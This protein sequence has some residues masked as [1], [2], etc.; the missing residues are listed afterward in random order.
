MEKRTQTTLAA[1]CGIT[2]AHLSSVE[3][4]LRNCSYPIA[5]LLGDITGSDPVIWLDGGGSPEERRAAVK[6]WA[7]Q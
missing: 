4:G 6:A 3:R 7:K 2:Q 5:K 1:E